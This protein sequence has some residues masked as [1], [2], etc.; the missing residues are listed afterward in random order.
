VPS[1]ELS[2][3]AR[4]GMRFDAPKLRF[5]LAQLHSA[6]SSPAKKLRHIHSSLG[7]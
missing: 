2:A 4:V 3:L 5:L 1:K 7:D 6:N